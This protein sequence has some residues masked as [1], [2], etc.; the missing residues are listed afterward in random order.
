MNAA[1][2]TSTLVPLLGL[3]PLGFAVIA[4]FIRHARAV[5]PATVR[6]GR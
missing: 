2:T 5:V 3:F 6:A 4:T 1:L